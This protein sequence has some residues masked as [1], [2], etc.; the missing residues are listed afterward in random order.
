MRLLIYLK[1]CDETGPHTS[2]PSLC[3]FD[4]L[5]QLKSPNIQDFKDFY[6]FCLCP[7]SIPSSNNVT[8][9]TAPFGSYGYPSTQP[10]YQQGPAPHADP[11]S[12]QEPYSQA[13]YNQFSQV[14]LRLESRVMIELFWNPSVLIY[15]NRRIP[16]Q[17]FPNLS[18]LSAALG[19]LSGVPELEVEALRAVNLLQ[20]RNL[21]PPRPLEAPEPNLSPELKK[22]N[23][24]PQSV[25]VLLRKHICNFCCHG[26]KSDVS[27]NQDI[28]VHLDQHP[29]DSGSTQQ[30]QASPGPPPPP[31][32]RLTGGLFYFIPGTQPPHS[33]SIASRFG[34]LILNSYRSFLDSRLDTWNVNKFRNFK[35]V[36]D[37]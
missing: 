16:P 24:S 23:C 12:S 21:L 28:Q 15:T 5:I 35:H 34:S 7:D 32:Q 37:V 29:P 20:E 8:N 1:A 9:Q 13:T 25:L 10:A 18:Q 11:S 33:T 27:D 26:L 6:F 4:H 30:G 2:A 22:V 31:I 14:R 17:P 36:K 19:G 3:C